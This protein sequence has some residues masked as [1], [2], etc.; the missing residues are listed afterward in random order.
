[1][2]LADK[3]GTAA[4]FDRAIADADLHLGVTEDV[5]ANYEAT[6]AGLN[7][8]LDK[9]QEAH[10]LLVIAQRV[11]SEELEERA[12]VNRGLRGLMENA[13]EESA[14]AIQSAERDRKTGDLYKQLLLHLMQ[15]T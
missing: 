6:I 12:A 13:R 5:R 7:A 10:D 4:D 8:K 9:L 15:E 11:A 1:M 3:G 2:N 14:R